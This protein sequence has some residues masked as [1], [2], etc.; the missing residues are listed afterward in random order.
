MLL[1][2][3]EGDFF[4]SPGKKPPAA[5]AASSAPQILPDAMAAP[6]ARAASLT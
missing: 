1:S 5:A 3:E 4:N 6:S 2:P